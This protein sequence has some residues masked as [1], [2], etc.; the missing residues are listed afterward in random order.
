LGDDGLGRRTSSEQIDKGAIE[1]ENSSSNVDEI[2]VII[3]LWHRVI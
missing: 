2:F 1:A 3:T